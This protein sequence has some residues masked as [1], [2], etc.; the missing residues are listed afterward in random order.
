MTIAFTPLQ[1][2]EA[3]KK[4]R[5]NAKAPVISKIEYFHKDASMRDFL[6]KMLLSLKRDDLFETSWLFRGRDL[7]QNN[8]FMLAYTIP[9]RVTDQVVITEEKDYREM[10]DQATD[11]A[12]NELKV[13]LVEQQV[14]CLVLFEPVLGANLR[15]S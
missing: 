2:S 5:A 9:R 11:R 1:P 14:S 10:V 8:S 7:H 15:E 6:A 4:R 3:G 12:P 13:Y